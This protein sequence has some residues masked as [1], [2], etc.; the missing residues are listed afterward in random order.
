MET[1]RI[2]NKDLLGTTLF[3][4]YISPFFVMALIP[5]YDIENP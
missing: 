4:D 2:L 1:K 5:G 3:T